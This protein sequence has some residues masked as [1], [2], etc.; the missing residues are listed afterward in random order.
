MIFQYN[1]VFFITRQRNRSSVREPCRPSN[2]GQLLI[3]LSNP[4]F[5]NPS[6]EHGHKNHLPRDNHVPL[7]QNQ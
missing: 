4:G 5:P 2:R 1:R 7:S 3:L 6:L